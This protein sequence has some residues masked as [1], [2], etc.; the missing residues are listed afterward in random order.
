MKLIDFNRNPTDRELKQFGATA[1]VVLPLIGWLAT[2]KPRSMEAMS[3]PL[4]G[5]LASL[6]LTRAI[7][8]FIRPQALRLPFITASLVTLPIG[9][10]V[11]EIVLLAIF[12][13]VFVPLGL[14]FRL[15]GRDALERRLDRSASTYWQPKRQ[16]DSPARYFRQF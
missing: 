16:P 12:Y 3:I 1:L 10:V 15:I 11:G 14:V 4:L 6:G 7:V 8:A 13:G 9:I 5:G 2:G